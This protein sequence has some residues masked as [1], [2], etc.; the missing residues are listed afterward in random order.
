MEGLHRQMGAMKNR[1]IKLQNIVGNKPN[2]YLVEWC[3]VNTD[4]EFTFDMYDCKIDQS[5]KQYTVINKAIKVDGKWNDG[6][7]D[8]QMDKILVIASTGGHFE[9]YD[10]NIDR[11]DQI[12]KKIKIKLY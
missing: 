9:F 6:T 10:E 8:A 12:Y 5:V 3:L 11:I 4:N 7:N 2:V 1:F